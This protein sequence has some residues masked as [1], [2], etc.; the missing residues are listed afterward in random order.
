MPRLILLLLLTGCS[1]EP[2]SSVE[3]ELLSDRGRVGVALWRENGCTLQPGTKWKTKP[4]F[5]DAPPGVRKHMC[6]YQW[7]EPRTDGLVDVA[8]LDLDASESCA[9]RTAWMNC[10]L[11]CEASQAQ[12]APA[13]LS[14]PTFGGAA[15]YAKT[16]NRPGGGG[17]GC[18]SC[19]VIEDDRAW[20]FYSP[21]LGETRLRLRAHATDTVVGDVTIARPGAFY[22]QLPPSLRSLDGARLDVDP[23]F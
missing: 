16:L 12:Y 1:I 8:P 17:G 14:V 22:V 6:F 18:D 3:S 13:D 23:I 21:Q 2:V 9:L 4:I 20:V 5:K 15:C 19:G 7:K 10:S 11:G